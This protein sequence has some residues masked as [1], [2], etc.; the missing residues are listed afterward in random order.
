LLGRHGNVLV[1]SI[2]ADQ[3][4]VCNFTNEGLFRTIKSTL[5]AKNANTNSEFPNQKTDAKDIQK[6]NAHA[7]QKI[8]SV[9]K[10]MLWT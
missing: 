4:M 6:D 5:S 7:V 1:Y 9:S 8:S 2:G 10:P 3:S